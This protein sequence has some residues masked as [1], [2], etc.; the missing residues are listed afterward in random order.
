V[1]EKYS[2]IDDAQK[3]AA[4]KAFAQDEHVFAV[5]GA[6][7]FETGAQCLTGRFHVPVVD[8][9]SVPSSSYQQG[10]PDYFTLHSDLTVFFRQYIDWADQQGL[11]KDHKIGIYADDSAKESVDAAKDE[12][13]KLGYTITSEV[14][15]NGAGVGSN[16]DQLAIQKF[17]QAGVDLMLPFVGGSS[18][19]NA[20]SYADKQG[21]HP[22]IVDLEYSEHTS[23]VAA[24]AI[25]SS[26][27]DGTRALTMA[28]VGAAAAGEAPTK[29]QSDCIDN[30]NTFS[31]KH[32]K[33]AS[34]ESSGELGNLLGVCSM[35]EVVLKGLSNA[36]ADPTPESFVSGLEQIQDMPIAGG[37]N[38]S[39]SSSEHWGIHQVRE[40]DWTAACSCWTAK[41]DWMDISSSS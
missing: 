26:I 10:A 11:L 8:L 14:T 33:F 32:V 16:S 27:Y 40:V 35:A 12:L 25:P 6:Q 30:Y 20:L 36:G 39:Y 13:S 15:T 23:D 5:I 17:Q 41:G 7:S 3:L 29:E 37:G 31:G 2:I 9:D 19:I 28:Y 18:L 21:Y 34:P 22:K 1:Y 24:A 38:V 4:C